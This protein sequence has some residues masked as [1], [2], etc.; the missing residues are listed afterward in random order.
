M[1]NPF[2]R[3]VSALLAIMMVITLV[4][5]QAF[6]ASEDGGESESLVSAGSF[7]LDFVE[8]SA[9]E[10]QED[11]VLGGRIV[12]TYGQ[13]MSDVS[14]QIYDQDENALL[15]LCTTDWSGAWTS[16]GYNAEDGHTY[17]LRFY[18]AGYSFSSNLLEYIAMPGDIGIDDVMT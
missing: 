14:V 8:E 6:A 11:S 7:D 3:F 4:P 9:P 2:K 17:V 18:K 16:A 10:Q 1:S 13:G 15:G 5:T 12:D